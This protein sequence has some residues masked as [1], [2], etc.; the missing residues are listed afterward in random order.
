MNTWKN[1][2]VMSSRPASTSNKATALAYASYVRSHAGASEPA[3]ELVSLLPKRNYGRIL[4]LCSGTGA[5]SRAI[6]STFP[7]ARV[8]AVEYSEAMIGEAHRDDPVEVI[9]IHARA[10]DLANLNLPT[11]DA[12]ICASGIWHTQL[13]EVLPAVRFALTP[14]GHFAFNVGESFLNFTSA[15]QPEGNKEFLR[16]LLMTAR[17]YG[18][19]LSKASAVDTEKLSLADLRGLLSSAGFDIVS[20]TEIAQHTGMAESQAWLSIPRYMPRFPGL[21]FEQT[22]DVIESTCHAMPP[23]AVISTFWYYVCAKRSR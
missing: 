13:A 21:S 22:L 19:Q 3:R 6:L 4:D 14:G 2:S 15:P 12:A 1:A 10:E 16:R 17:G 7:D 11:F 8:W 18:A 5:A 9:H 20:E 23:D